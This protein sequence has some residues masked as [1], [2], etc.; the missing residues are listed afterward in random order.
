[1]LDNSHNLSGNKR[2]AKN[3]LFL[4][5]R[6]I[7]TVLISLYTARI[8]L[9]ELGVDNYGVYNVVGGIVMLFAS[10]RGLFTNAIQRYLNFEIAKEDGDVSKVF[11]LGLLIHLLLALLFFIL[12]E[13]VGAIMF[14][15]LNIPPDRLFAAKIVFQ[16]SVLSAIISIIT[17]PYNAVL[18]SR[19]KMDVFAYIAIIES[20]G[21]LAIVYLISLLPFDILINY[22]LLVLFMSILV[23]YIY[24]IYCTRNFSE[25]LFRFK[26]D[27]QLFKELSTFAGWNF[28]GNLAFSL[29][30]EGINFL[31]NMFGGVAVNAARGISYQIKSVLQQLFGNIMIA[32]RPQSTVLY[33]KQQYNQFYTLLFQSSKLVFALFTVIC[34][35]LYVFLP[36]VL[37]LWLGQIPE[38]TVSIM[39]AIIVYM[40]IRSFHEPLDLVFVSSGRLKKYQLC[41]LFV[42]TMSIP[43]AYFILKM[44][45]DY[46]WVFIG[47]AVV[48]AINLIAITNIARLQ[49]QF[50]LMDYIKRVHLPCYTLMAIIICLHYVFSLFISNSQSVV[51]VLFYI[52]CDVLVVVGLVYS[53]L[54]NKSERQLINIIVRKMLKK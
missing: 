41:E 53:V 23:G 10:L 31:L 51:V 27:K 14:P 15:K 26:W 38:Y 44:G 48:E 36:F 17:I 24:Y 7:V 8:L 43:V 3:A 33:A 30:N 46:Y 22:G 16:F 9:Q 4:Y 6:M 12:V 1:M 11:S 18:I 35:P 28:A 19:E 50:P 45:L 21:K 20:I 37:E 2:I 42:L 49:V 47:M 34:V 5:V 54:L 32:Y 52:F 25:A 40:M 39:R 29:T 13:I